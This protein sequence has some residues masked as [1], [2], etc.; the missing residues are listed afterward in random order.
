MHYT[1][2]SNA[3]AEVVRE[4]IML[5]EKVGQLMRVS[6]VNYLLNRRGRRERRAARGDIRRRGG[7]EDRGRET[8]G[9]R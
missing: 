1:G 4:V 6:V 7:G 2:L 9:R 8:G 3:G 5:R